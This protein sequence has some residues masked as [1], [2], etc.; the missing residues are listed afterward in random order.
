M[1]KVN[2]ILFAYINILGNNFKKQRNDTE[3]MI[4][5]TWDRVGRGSQFKELP[6]HYYYDF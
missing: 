1:Q 5:V 3:I 2:N 4:M 6:F